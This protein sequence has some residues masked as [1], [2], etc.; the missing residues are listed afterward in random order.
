MNRFSI[1]VGEITINILPLGRMIARIHVSGY[2]PI[3][4]GRPPFFSFVSGV[5]RIQDYRIELVH[6]LIIVSVVV[7]LS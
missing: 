5:A 7:I 4:S 6:D 3:V 1:C 2:V